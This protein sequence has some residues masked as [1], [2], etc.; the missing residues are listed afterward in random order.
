MISAIGSFFLFAMLAIAFVSTG[1]TAGPMFRGAIMGG[2]GMFLVL[3]LAVIW[4]RKGNTNG[5]RPP[6]SIEDRHSA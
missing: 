2:V 1:G 3:A 4:N 5:A 6:E